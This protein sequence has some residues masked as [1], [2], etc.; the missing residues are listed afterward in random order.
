MTETLYKITKPDGT[1]WA[2]DNPVYQAGRRYRATGTGTPELCTD[3]VL[4]ASRTPEQAAWLGRW[5]YVLWEVQG[6]V[7]VEDDMK[8]GCRQINVVR[9]L[10]VHLC[11]GPNGREVE[12]IIRRVGRITTE[13]SAR[14]A[15]AR[16]AERDA[17]RAAAR[18]AAWDAERAAVRAA[19]RAAERDAVRAA[20][21]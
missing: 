10:P 7:A 21:W 2:A 11:W 1:P 17:V 15:A 12:R 18:D 13:E 16:A 4:H 9:L 8:V 19:A 5:P 3:T 6:K 20:A 14:L